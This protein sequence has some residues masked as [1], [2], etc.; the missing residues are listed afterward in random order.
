MTCKT[1]CPTLPYGVNSIGHC[2][3]CHETFVGNTA[4]DTH[5]RRHEDG[6]TYCPPLEGDWWQDDR[7]YWHKG[8]RLT[9]EQKQRIWGTSNARQG[10]NHD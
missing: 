6:T 9:E 10:E 3:K 8:K 7:G 1:T 2:S 5:F 4:F